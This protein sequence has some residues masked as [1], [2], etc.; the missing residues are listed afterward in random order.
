[1]YK[2]IFSDV[3]GT[4]LNSSHV[5][6][7][8][9]R[10]TL[11]NLDIPFVIVSA[12][13]PSGIYPILKD[14]HLTCAIIAYSGGLIL[15][16]DGQVLFH[17]GI[18]KNEAKEIINFLEPFD[19]SWCAYSLDEWIVKDKNDPRILNEENIVK[20]YA[21]QGYI[22]DFKDDQ[23]NKILC[24]CNKLQTH[25]IEKALK[26]KFPQYSIVKSSDILIEI[27]QQG[28]NKATAIERLCHIWNIDI[29][30]TLAFGDN[31]NDYEM[32][33]T[34]GKGILMGNAPDDL[35]KEFD[36]IT[37]D[38]DHDGIYEALKSK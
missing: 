24:I 10:E 1:M 11:Q 28:I 33:K 8:K 22:D 7:P 19:C 31:Y 35:K 29:N 3:D 12:R 4:L 36:D 18:S 38:N 6:T 15:D 34:C 13:S 27:M 32:L 23:V 37:L 9:T 25:I 2:I 26:E 20:A 5:V 16:E 21:T 17:Q 14:N 30:D